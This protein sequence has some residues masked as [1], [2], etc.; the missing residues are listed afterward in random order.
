LRYDFEV[1][2]DRGLHATPF[3]RQRAVGYWLGLRAK[4]L[5]GFF[6]IRGGTIVMR[7]RSVDYYSHK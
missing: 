1:F 6:I 4:Q 2:G 5:T 7:A 3:V